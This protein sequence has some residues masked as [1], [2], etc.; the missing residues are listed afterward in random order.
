MKVYIIGN[1]SDFIIQKIEGLGFEISNKQA[2]SIT[3]AIREAEIIFSVVED[4]DNPI[5]HSKIGLAIGMKIA[6]QNKNIIVFSK[7]KQVTKAYQSEWV[8]L[9]TSELHGL[10]FLPK[11]QKDETENLI[12][13]IENNKYMMKFLLASLYPYLVPE[14]G[15]N[16]SV[17]ILKED[18]DKLFKDVAVRLEID[19]KEN[20]VIMYSSRSG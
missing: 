8:N 1:V 19:S 18:V 10:S 13:N 14:A 4:K 6:G 17:C 20:L 2:T 11:L 16:V 15:E 7:E 3:K 5:I 12:K 9:A